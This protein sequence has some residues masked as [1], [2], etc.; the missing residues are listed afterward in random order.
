MSHSRASQAS[1]SMGK[2]WQR[3]FYPWGSGRRTD[4]PASE[5]PP[6][7]LTPVDARPPTPELLL[8][9]RL[10]PSS[11]GR[12]TCGKEGQAALIPGHLP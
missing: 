3:G 7:P 8:P 2:T 10:R 11:G 9:H 12:R 5:C 4:F 6:G 1:V